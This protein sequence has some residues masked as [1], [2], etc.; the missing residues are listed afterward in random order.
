[1]SY[2]KVDQLKCFAILNQRKMTTEFPENWVKELWM[3]TVNKF[4]NLQLS[5]QVYNF[6]RV[7]FKR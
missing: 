6:Y 7:A 3:R 1:M 2:P 5:M 4:E